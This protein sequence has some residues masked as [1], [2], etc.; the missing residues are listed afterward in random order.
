MSMSETYYDRQMAQFRKFMAWVKREGGVELPTHL[1]T[2]MQPEQLARLT[3]LKEHCAGKVLEVGCN[4]GYVLAWVGGHTGL[5]INATNIELA[6]LLSPDRQFIEGDAVS[7]PFPN[8]SFDTVMLP[9]TLEHL[10]WPHGVHAAVS[11]A[12]RVAKGKVLITIPDGR[13]DSDPACSFK[14]IWLLT[15]EYARDLVDW[16][17]VTEPRV[18]LDLTYMAGFAFIEADLTGIQ[19]TG[20]RR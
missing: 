6:R 2:L 15:E 13:T 3:W 5:D 7:L 17:L 10:D 16:I 12:M 14:H 1:D 8:E 9:D 11:E 19:K 18:K 20:E 4:F